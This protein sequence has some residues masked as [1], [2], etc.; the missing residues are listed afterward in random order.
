M[1]VKIGFTGDFCPNAR[2]SNLYSVGDWKRSVDPV[3]LFFESN[4][5]NI[6]G[7]ECPLIENGKRIQKTG[8]YLKS[9]TNVAEV[10][11]YL[12]SKMV[13]T[14]NNHFLDYGVEGILSTKESLAAWNI[15]T[16]GSGRNLTESCTPGIL[17]I[18]GYKIA[19]LNFA[20]NE[21]STTTGENPGVNP[22]DPI[23]NFYQITSAKKY[24]DFVVVVTHGGHEHYELPSPKM[25]SLF[26]YYIDA[27]ADAVINSH[28]HTFSGYEI[29][30]KRP[31]FY[32]LGNFCFDW[33]GKK[34]SSWNIGMLVSLKFEK[35]KDIDF[36]IKFIRQFDDIPAI[37]FL[38]NQDLVNCIHRLDELNAIIA[39]DD[40][41]ISKFNDFCNSKAP[42]FKLWLEPFSNKYLLALIRRGVFPRLLSKR[43]KILFTN[44]IRCES[45]REILLKTLE[46]DIK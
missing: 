10:I 7:L 5:E 6:I 14:A 31:I 45:H 11:S 25:K 19:I 24:V 27:G 12:N 8:P 35:N 46:Q 1:R 22:I 33:P 4:D 9:Q 15:N 34:N 13:V 39:N 38:S 32:S 16:V 41:L 43:K 18:N 28:T 26:R 20:E 42:V 21:W 29:Y 44:L 2:F 40:Q 17:E 30:K 36:E 3:R 37:Q 23:L